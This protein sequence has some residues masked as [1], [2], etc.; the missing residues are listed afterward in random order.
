MPTCPS[1]FTGSIGWPAGV[2][3]RSQMFINVQ[4][5]WV[6]RLL[7][8]PSSG[9]SMSHLFVPGQQQEDIAPHTG[10][11]HRPDNITSDIITEGGGGGCTGAGE[12][13]R[14]SLPAGT[15]PASLPCFSVLTDGALWNWGLCCGW[16]Y[17]AFLFVC[18]CFVCC[19]CLNDEHVCR[20]WC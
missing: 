2:I 19:L 17:W 12:D 11:Q 16:K 9:G 18:F 15:L 1:C 3:T 6:A 8:V 5:I 4:G 10:F 13:S 20:G 14:D 7:M